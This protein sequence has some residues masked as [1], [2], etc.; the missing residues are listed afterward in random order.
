M[1]QQSKPIP[2]Q[3]AFIFFGTT[4]SGKSYLAGSWAAANSYVYL[5]TDAIRK[6]LATRPEQR[7]ESAPGIDQGIYSGEFTRLTYDT[8]LDEAEAAFLNQVQVVVIDGSYIKRTER[9]RLMARLSGLAACLFI[10]C[11][12]SE[13]TVKARL[14]T[15]AS[16]Q[17]AVSD[18]TWE[19]YLHQQQVLE[20]PAELS[21]GQLI[22]LN[23]ERPLAELIAQLNEQLHGK[24]DAA[25][26]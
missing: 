25:A 11:V 5:N 6:K 10:H 20:P 14:A 12:C 8:I 18:G 7:Q 16:D 1:P 9:D 13:A 21:P 3:K 26:L 24:T 17:D 4:A 2:P 23:T 22:T 19:I 15:R